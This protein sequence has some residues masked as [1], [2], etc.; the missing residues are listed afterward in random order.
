ASLD[1]TIRKTLAEAGVAA[2]V[3]QPLDAMLGYFETMLMARGE[4]PPEFT[5]R[6]AAI[7]ADPN[8]QL[9]FASLSPK[10]EEEARKAVETLGRIRDASVKK[11]Y[12]VRIFEANL[13]VPLKNVDAAVDD[14]V[15]ALT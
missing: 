12:V 14:F 11:K 5:E 1:A 13:Q 2:S 7:I 8:V 10:S 6:K 4:L 15:A 3:H 9:L